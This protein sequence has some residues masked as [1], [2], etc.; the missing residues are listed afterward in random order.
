MAKF[1]PV[2]ILRFEIVDQPTTFHGVMPGKFGTKTP[3]LNHGAW[4]PKG[5]GWFPK[6]TTPRTISTRSRSCCP[7][8]SGGQFSVPNFL[9]PNFLLRYT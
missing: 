5:P 9:C 2:T 1:T 6:E 3:L 4:P 8:D 7:P